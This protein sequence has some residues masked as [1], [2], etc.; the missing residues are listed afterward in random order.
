MRP[1]GLLFIV[2]L[3]LTAIGCGRS[4][5]GPTI[6]DVR[7]RPALEDPV[8]WG[9]TSRQRFEGGHHGAVAHGSTGSAENSAGLSWTLPK[10]WV[11]LPSQEMRVVSI[12]PDPTSEA[13]CYV[14]VLRGAAGGITANVNRWRE[15]MGLEALDEEGV[16]ALPTIPVLGRDC[17]LVELAGSF[18]DMDGQTEAGAG[19][20][21]VV[22]PRTSDTL[23]VKMTGPAAVVRAE[24]ARFEAFCRSLEEQGGR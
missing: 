5:V 14:T 11:A 4:G 16:K 24:R 18:T 21:G 6:G 19:M 12:R 22:C 1:G 23:F 15:Q 9:L 10:G 8:P 7:E 20:L 3:P 13:E 17:V 2:L